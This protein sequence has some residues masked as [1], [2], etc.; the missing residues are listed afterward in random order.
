MTGGAKCAALLAM[1]PDPPLSPGPLS[2]PK[3]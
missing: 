1:G 3:H 2:Q